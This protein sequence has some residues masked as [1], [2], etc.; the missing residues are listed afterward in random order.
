MATQWNRN[1][2]NRKQRK[3]GQAFRKMV[4][5]CENTVVVCVEQERVETEVKIVKGWRDSQT[6]EFYEVLKQNPYDNRCYKGEQKKQKA[7]EILDVRWRSQIYFTVLTNYKDVKAK[8]KSFSTTY[9]M[10]KRNRK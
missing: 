1:Q 4:T 9:Y 3:V 8:A 10:E 2:K 7:I 6:E 5:I